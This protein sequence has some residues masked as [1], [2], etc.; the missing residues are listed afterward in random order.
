MTEVLNDR[1]AWLKSG[2]AKCSKPPAVK[3]PPRRYILLGPPGAGKGTQA[4]LLAARIGGCQLS[5]GDVFR[6]A[7]NTGAA[8]Q[9]PAVRT[10]LEAMAKGELVQDETVLEMIRERL[11]C[12]HCGGGILLDGFPR[13]VAQAE[14][15]TALL[16]QQ[17]IK[18]DGVLNYELPL[19]TIVA[20]LGGR[21]ICQTCKAVYHVENQPPA[22]PEVCDKCGGDVIQRDDDQPEAIRVRMEAYERSTLPLTEYYRKQG[23]LRTISAAG[24]PEE[25]HHRTL[26]VLAQ[27]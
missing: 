19:A 27:A 10:A 3:G 25:V 4:E 5:T 2:A 13:T 6:A 22:T 17:K 8:S 18:L 26:T 9:S 12:L 21:R 14:A 16:R 11:R 7:K 1:A 20:R 15:L 23:L 24:S